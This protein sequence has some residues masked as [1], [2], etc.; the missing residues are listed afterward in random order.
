MA[1]AALC[2]VLVSWTARAWAAPQVWAVDDGEKILG[3]A[4]PGALANGEGNAVYR[5]GQPI[6]L[7]A[8]QDEVVAFQVVITAD[9]QDLPAVTVDL[10]S[11]A[12]PCGAVLRNQAGATDPARPLGRRIERF[13][14]HMFS[15]T[16]PSRTD[17][18]A[19]ASLGWSA[20]SAPP[21]GS[22]IGLVPDAL[23]PVEWAPA[24]RPYPL[25]VPARQ[26]G[27]VWIDVS[28]PADQ[29]PGLYRGTV[30][31]TGAGQS[32]AELPVELQVVGQRLPYRSL[33]T[34]FYY[35]REELDRRMNGGDAAE[36]QLWQL[37]HRHSL[38]PLPS[39]LSVSD[40]RPLHQALD[41]SLYRSAQG[42]DGPGEGL[43][44]DVLA[45]GTYGSYGAPTAAKAAQVEAIAD[46]LAQAGVLASTDV[47][48]YAIDE[49]CSSSYGR[50]WVDLLRQSSNANAQKVRVA[51]TCSQDPTG[52]VVDIPI[53]WAAMY[54]PTRAAS[55]SAAGKTV[56]IYN[57]SMPQTG[58]FL[59]DAEAVSIRANGWLGALYDIG[60][61]FYW[62]S[63]FWYDNNRG[64]HGAYDP[65]V[66]PETFHNDYGDSANG[67]GVL[68]YPG[69]QV[70]G[71]GE[72]SL[73]VAAVLP[74]IRLKNLRRGIQDAGYFQL[75]RAVDQ[76]RA[77]QIGDDLLPAPFSRA[78][79]GDPFVGK[80]E[81][82]FEAR[83]QLL[84]VFRA[85]ATPATTC[86]PASPDA[87]APAVIADAGSALDA[88]SS[89][90][91]GAP[92]ALDAAALPVAPDAAQIDS[93]DVNSTPRPS[94]AVAGCSMTDA[95]T[96]VSAR[97]L[98]GLGLALALL[99]RRRR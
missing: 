45:L 29:E 41:G 68:V 28:V 42:Y 84:D 70:D 7:V 73:G 88:P 11:L 67:D 20:G 47:F 94:A 44:D 17:D 83:Q 99:R 54:D 55:A 14:E 30:H 61:W 15:I 89:R 65:F 76:T 48:V 78:R 60:R 53:V 92:P 85:G 6:R 34:M 38:S 74:S 72:H 80:G 91:G 59:T 51:W 2:G 23:I 18:R 57:G 39:A 4:P 46:D 77:R 69:R 10:D 96:S 27:L 71:F 52:Q 21:A 58:T 5:P 82:F 35:S 87:G 79:A 26:N 63:T 93:R 31:V 16:Q 40:V 25:H 98:V 36:R 3:D 8:L 9:E 22:F 97:L 19:G 86:D 62:E 43:G 37:F 66:Q 24:W 1:I 50:Q 64:G 49:D 32:L 12:G 81:A 95:T 90:D 33:R 56:W 75:A 13:V